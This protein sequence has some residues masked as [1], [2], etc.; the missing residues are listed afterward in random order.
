MINILQTKNKIMTGISL[1]L[2][3]FSLTPTNVN[4]NKINNTKEPPPGIVWSKTYGGASTDQSWSVQQTPDNGFI[5]AGK[6]LV[7]WCRRL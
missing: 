4:S 5:I 3:I 6:N 7:I 2:I 1:I